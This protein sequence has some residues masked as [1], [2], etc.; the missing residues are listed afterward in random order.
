MDNHHENL[1]TLHIFQMFLE[2]R[3]EKGFSVVWDM[4][5]KEDIRTR[6]SKLEHVGHGIMEIIQSSPSRYY[7][8]LEMLKMLLK[9]KGF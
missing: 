2:Q 8:S 9:Q 4:L 5:A 7:Y 1:A 6:D 3:N